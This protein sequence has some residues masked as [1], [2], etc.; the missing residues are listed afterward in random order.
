MSAERAAGLTETRPRRF[1]LVLSEVFSFVPT[2]VIMT[3]EDD[4]LKQLM[5]DIGERRLLKRK[6]CG[7]PH[8]TMDAAKHAQKTAKSWGW[9][10]TQIEPRAN[11][12]YYVVTG[13]DWGSFPPQ[14][15]DGVS[16]PG[17]PQR[18][19]WPSK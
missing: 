15:K 16:N 12:E 17:L 10:D 5:S 7:K 13:Y 9:H 6:V 19:R 14:N 3:T 8:K 11:G 4:D 18:Y 2:G 1:A